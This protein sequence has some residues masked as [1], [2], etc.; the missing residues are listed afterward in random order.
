M[1]PIKYLK[2]L[3]AQDYIKAKSKLNCSNGCWEWVGHRLKK[4]YGQMRCGKKLVLAHRASWA[5]FKGEI[6]VGL[7]VLHKCDNPS[8]CNPEHLFLGTN[9]DNMNDMVAKGRNN[10]PRRSNHYKWKAKCAA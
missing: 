10:H 9:A 4:G 3:S 2:G 1:R 8:C 5:A 7:F 6:P